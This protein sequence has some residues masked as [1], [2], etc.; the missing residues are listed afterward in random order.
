MFTI[1]IEDRQPVDALAICIQTPRAI[2]LPLLH[3]MRRANCKDRND[4]SKYNRNHVLRLMLRSL[5]F[6]RYTAVYPKFDQDV[7]EIVFCIS[8]LWSAVKL[9]QRWLGKLTR[10]RNQCDRS[11]GLDIS[12]SLIFSSYAAYPIYP[13]TTPLNQNCLLRLT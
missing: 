1:C 8:M 9:T 3:W 5:L 12:E 6:D 13:E 7:F 11:P 2:G 10:I 4:H